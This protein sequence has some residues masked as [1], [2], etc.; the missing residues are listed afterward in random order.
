MFK[1]DAQRFEKRIEGLELE[2]KLLKEALSDQGIDPYP[3]H[4]NYC[5]PVKTILNFTSEFKRLWDYLGVELV[6][7]PEKSFLKEKN[8]DE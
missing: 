2:I 8:K 5:F 3:E 6:T 1:K 4:F 7:E